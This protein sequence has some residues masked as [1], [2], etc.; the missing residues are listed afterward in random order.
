MPLFPRPARLIRRA[1]AVLALASLA[2]GCT[3]LPA[4]VPAGPPD[5]VAVEEPNEPLR[6]APT[7]APKAS[8]PRPEAEAEAEPA[9]PARIADG[10]V[11]FERLAG[12][13]GPPVC[14]RG[15]HNRQWRRRYAGHPA[16]FERQLREAL[17]LMAYV[18]EAVEA[19]NLP[20][21][22]AL[23][24]IVESGYRPEA[25]GPGG[26]TGLWQMIGST[27]RNHG[28]QV[29]R[30]YDGRLSPVDATDAALDYLA[31]LHAEFGDWRATA[32]AYNAGEGRLRRAFARDGA[33]RVSGERRLPAG[34]SSVTYAYVA[35]LHALACLIAEPARHGLTLPVDAFTPLEARRAPDGATRLDAVARAW[36]TSPESLARWNPAYR[37][38]IALPGAPRRLLAPVGSA[39]AM[40]PIASSSA[41][42]AG[43]EEAPA[44]APRQH[45]VRSG[46]TLWRIARRYG[47]TVRALAAFNGIDAARP[48]RIGRTLRIPD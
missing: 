25:R 21:E 33:S 28:V 31:V 2:V 37:A 14:V 34:L 48:L 32:M 45:T 44:E 27:A 7:P 8:V 22:F 1:S 47:T 11:L 24:P 18:V 39:V 36:G 4:P 38:G 26:P 20:G 3:T 9:P 46:E 16:S 35:K 15:D 30:G 6:L 13:F 5:P 10:R 29:G 12:S 42:L 43:N 17:P 19:R 41:P 40:T 23:I